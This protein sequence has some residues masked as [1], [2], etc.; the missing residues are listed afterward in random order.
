MVNQPAENLIRMLRRNDERVH[1]RFIGEND[2]L[3]SFA[4]FG[5]VV[6]IK[7]VVDILCVGF[8]GGM[9]DFHKGAVLSVTGWDVFFLPAQGERFSAKMK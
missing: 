1:C 7:T 2:F 3:R 9:N 4:G 6:G 8:P 5:T